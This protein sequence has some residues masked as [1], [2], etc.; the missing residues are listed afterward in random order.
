[1]RAFTDRLRSG[2]HVGHSGDVI[3]DVV[4]IGIGGSDLGPLMVA[5]ALRPFDEPVY[6]HQTVARRD[7]RL[8]RYVD[9][10]EAFAS[11]ETSTGGQWR[12]H[13]HVPIFLDRME[14]FGTTQDFLR[15]I[16]SLHKRQ[17]IS[18][19]LEVETYTWDVLPARYRDL[20]LAGAISRELN[21]VRD[22]LA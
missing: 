15:D 20:D 21:W 4:N 14:H 17:P 12:S 7:G 10:D 9:L 6:L 5:E 16:L 11:L 13:F 3:T 18:E 19:H 8:Y 2:M 22:R 1:M